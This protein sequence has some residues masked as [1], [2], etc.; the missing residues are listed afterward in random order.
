[1]MRLTSH[2]SANRCISSMHVVGI[3]LVVI[4]KNI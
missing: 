2:Y 4:A 1:M 3:E